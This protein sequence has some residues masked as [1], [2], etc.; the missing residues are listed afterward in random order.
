M[1][2][3]KWIN[4]KLNVEEEELVKNKEAKEE[5]LRNKVWLSV[6][7]EKSDQRNKSRCEIL[8]DNYGFLRWWKWSTIPMEEDG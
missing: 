3:N 8:L 2:E 4:K 6:E 1:R 5:T 7:M